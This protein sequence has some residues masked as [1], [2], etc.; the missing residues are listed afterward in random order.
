ME[1]T[2]PP[3]D[4]T[5]SSLVSRTRELVAG[6]VAFVFNVLHDAPPGPMA[7]AQIRLFLRT[8]IKPG[9]AL[10]RRAIYLLA[11]RLPTPAPRAAT[12]RAA[13]PVRTPQT[14]TPRRLIPAFR[15]TEP[16]GLARPGKP[17][18]AP[19]PRTG[20]APDLYAPSEKFV[21]RLAALQ[22]ACA[23]PDKFAR[24]LRRRLARRRLPA[25][26]LALRPPSGI[27]Q[28]RS[29]DTKSLYASLA[30]AANAAWPKLRNT[31]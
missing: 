11:A 20:A 15:L 31:S 28:S 1:H 25:L 16:A 27:T 22:A 21:R 2:L 6:L 9:E 29:P 30:Q 17:G 4:E 12:V 14:Q 5:T 26:P 18:Q 19:P 8:V 7:L 13:A 3:P 23:D 10:L 24:L